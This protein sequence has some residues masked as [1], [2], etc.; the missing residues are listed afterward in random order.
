REFEAMVRTLRKGQPVTAQGQVI[1]SSTSFYSGNPD[2]PLGHFYDRK[3]PR[4]PGDL[5]VDLFCPELA[6][7]MLARKAPSVNQKTL[8]GGE[9]SIFKND[10]SAAQPGFYDV[11]PE[12]DEFAKRWT[13]RLGREVDVK[14]RLDLELPPAP[15]SGPIEVF[16]TVAP[17]PAPLPKAPDAPKPK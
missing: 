16:R 13:K 1:G 10:G 4:R 14:L 6:R 3:G 15:T 8:V 12:V 7:D 2:K 9:R 17:P 5:D 11:F